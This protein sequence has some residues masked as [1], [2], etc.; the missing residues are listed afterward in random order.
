MARNLFLTGRVKCGK[1]TLLK[2]EI[3]PYLGKIG[4]YYVRRIFCSGE[5]RGFRMMELSDQKSYLLE[6]EAGSIHKEKDLV[7]YLSDNGNWEPCEKTFEVTGAEIL[8]RA[9]HSGKKVIL[10][11]ELGTAEQFSPRFR[12]MVN[13]LLDS[14]LS[15]LGVIKKERNPFLDGIR[16]RDD[17]T[18]VDLDRWERREAAERVRSFLA[19]AGLGG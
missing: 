19:E 13:M 11:D 12:R 7:V 10:M 17:V 5:H 14:S 2:Q 3:T 16:E 4:G 6:Q 9:Y 1:S 15:V 8:K 18:V